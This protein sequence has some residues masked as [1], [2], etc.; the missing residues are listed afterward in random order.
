LRLCSKRNDVGQKNEDGARERPTG[1]S[2]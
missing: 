1:E 2:H